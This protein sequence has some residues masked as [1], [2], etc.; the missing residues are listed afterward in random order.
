MK[1]Q[2]Q[3]PLRAFPLLLANLELRPVLDKTCIYVS[4]RKDFYHHMK[5]TPERAATNVWPPVS[6]EDLEGT[7]ALA[8]WCDRNLKKARYDRLKHGDLFQI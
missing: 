1:A 3:E 2:F 8:M 5:V 6:R 7:A 4:D